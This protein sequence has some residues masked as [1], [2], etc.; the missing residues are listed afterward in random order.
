MSSPRMPEAWRWEGPVSRGGRDAGGDGC[1]ALPN[2]PVT[3]R[4]AGSDAGASPTPSRE[5]FQCFAYGRAARV[6]VGQ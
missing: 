5:L 1:H 2:S 3:N 4:F 6:V